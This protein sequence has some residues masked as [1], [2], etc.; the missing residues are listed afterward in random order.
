MSGTSACPV[1][2]MPA[3][4]VFIG[5]WPWIAAYLLI[6]IGA[7]MLIFG[8]IHFAR[9]VQILSACF[10]FCFLSLLLSINGYIEQKLE[11]GPN[12]G[13]SILIVFIILLGIGLGLFLGKL[14]PSRWASFFMCVVTALVLSLVVYS[15]LMAFTSG[16]VVLLF[17]AIILMITCS[18]LPIYFE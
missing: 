17:C 11:E 10:I 15:F 3:F 9:I 14:I 4:T 5:S 6:G 1:L 2:S 8:R 12:A 13:I 7:Y 16:L 18:I